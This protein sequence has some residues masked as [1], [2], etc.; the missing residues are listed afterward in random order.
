MKDFHSKIKCS[1]I[2]SVEVM[3]A[4]APAARRPT[5]DNSWSLPL[6]SFC[7]IAIYERKIIYKAFATKSKT[8]FT[9]RRN[10]KFQNSAYK[11]WKTTALIAHAHQS[12]EHP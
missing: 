11:I 10:L 4:H 5:T 9:M 3:P 8:F 2:T 6:K 7:C 12:L 1:T